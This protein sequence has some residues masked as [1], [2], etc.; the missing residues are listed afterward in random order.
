VIKSEPNVSQIE[1]NNNLMAFKRKKTQFPTTS[2]YFSKDFKII[3]DLFKKKSFLRKS[4]ISKIIIT[5]NKR[6]KT[7]FPSIET[8]QELKTIDSIEREPNI[9][10]IVS[11]NSQEL[12]SRLISVICDPKELFE[13]HLSSDT[14][15]I[16]TENNLK[17]FENES[18][19]ESI[20]QKNNQEF[21]SDVN[22]GF[23]DSKELFKRPLSLSSTKVKTEDNCKM[24]ETRFSLDNRLAMFENS[25]KN[26][27]CFNV[28]KSN[29][30][31]G[32]P[33]NCYNDSNQTISDKFESISNY[34]K[35]ESVVKSEKLDNYSNVAKMNSFVGKKKKSLSDILSQKPFTPKVFASLKLSKKRGN[36]EE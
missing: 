10:S 25:R 17:I 15:T 18:N 5:P 21:E 16:R 33:F 28:L 30:Y 36:I 9:P 31:S 23:S 7:G 1:T 26:K 6:L 32:N 20:V 11:Q 13:S 29:N 27:I 14:N 4:G 3:D 35:S 19:N 34:F 24:S 8:T 22:S 2:K 12:R